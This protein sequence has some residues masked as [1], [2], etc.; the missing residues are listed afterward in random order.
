MVNRYGPSG[1]P[2]GT[3]N[4]T[5]WR[6]DENLQMWNDCVLPLMYDEKH[7]SDFSFIPALSEML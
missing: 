2:Y 7:W 3:P 6:S 1:E 4:S 5:G